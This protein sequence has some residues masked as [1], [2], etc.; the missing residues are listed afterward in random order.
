MGAG[1]VGL[2]VAWSLTTR[3]VLLNSTHTVRMN[4]AS[5]LHTGCQTTHGKCVATYQEAQ[6]TSLIW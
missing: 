4:L 2:G 5:S 1:S 3:A 6:L